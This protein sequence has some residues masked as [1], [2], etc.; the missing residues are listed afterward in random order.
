MF[1]F[2]PIEGHRT[3]RKVHPGEHWFGAK[4]K[5]RSGELLFPIGTGRVHVS[6]GRYQLTFEL[7]PMTS[8]SGSVRGASSDSELHVAVASAEGFLLALE[9]GEEELHR[10]LELGATQTFEWDRVPVGKFELWLGTRTEL[11]AETPRLRR[12]IELVHGEP[13]SIELEIE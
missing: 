4:G 9:T 7:R 11:L 6:P 1:Q 5:S 12:P 10:T 13:L 8:L 2:W 3:V